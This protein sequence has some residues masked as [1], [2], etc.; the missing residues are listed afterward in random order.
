M[1]RTL[2]AAT[3]AGALILAGCTQGE[4]TPEP[5]DDPNPTPSAPAELTVDEGGFPFGL[6][7]RFEDSY[8]AYCVEPQKLSEATLAAINSRASAEVEAFAG[9]AIPTEEA[10]LWFLTVTVGDE[11]SGSTVFL[12]AK[13]SSINDLSEFTAADAAARSYF[14]LN[15][16]FTV[17]SAE[18]KRALDA[19]LKYAGCSLPLESETPTI[20]EIPA[21]EIPEPTGEP[22]ESDFVVPED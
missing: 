13:G 5:T 8:P 4:T 20:D 14:D 17:E 6:K 18:G 3:L 16:D 11:N 1:R 21:E 7:E 10:D 12:T 15:S 2:L 22:E 9:T 19:F